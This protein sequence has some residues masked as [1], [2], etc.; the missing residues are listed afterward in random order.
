MK[1]TTFVA[2]IWYNKYDTFHTYILSICPVPFLKLP[3]ACRTVLR[4]DIQGRK[5]ERCH[6]EMGGYHL[7]HKTQFNHGQPAPH[8][9]PLVFF[10]FRL[11]ILR[12][13]LTVAILQLKCQDWHVLASPSTTPAVNSCPCLIRAHI[14]PFHQATFNFLRW[15]RMEEKDISW[16]L[17]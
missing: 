14:V 15:Q 17:I 8:P 6:S 12:H 3:R 4:K 13:L 5:R 10:F 9:F 16:I 7:Y 2:E 1:K 11:S